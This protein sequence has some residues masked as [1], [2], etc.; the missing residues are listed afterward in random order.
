MSYKQ[1]TIKEANDIMSMMSALVALQVI[2]ME[3]II[4]IML[5]IETI[6]KFDLIYNRSW[7]FV[8]SEDMEDYPWYQGRSNLLSD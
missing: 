4:E 6:T 3:D 1:L 5:Q 2:D 7:D 8:S